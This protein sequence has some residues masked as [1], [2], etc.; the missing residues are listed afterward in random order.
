[1]MNVYA[2]VRNIHVPLDNTIFNVT[3]SCLHRKDGITDSTPAAYTMNS[4]PKG[5]IMSI[6]KQFGPSPQQ[7]MKHNTHL[8]RLT[9][10]ICRIREDCKLPAF[11]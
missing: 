2:L 1:M 4:L 3:Q 7:A 11:W 10:S 6:A 5:M 8:L 9:I